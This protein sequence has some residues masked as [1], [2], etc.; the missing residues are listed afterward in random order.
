MIVSPDRHIVDEN[1]NQT[2]RML[3]WTDQ[4]T[5]LQPL[6][7]SG[8][9]ETVIPAPIAT[10]YMNTA[11]VAGSILYVKRDANI[12]GDKTQGWILV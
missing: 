1:G 5:K 9:P 6:T 8:S 2:Q 12:G 7:G 11:G 10:L 4:V 3:T